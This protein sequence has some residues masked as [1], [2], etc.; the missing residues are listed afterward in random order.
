MSLDPDTSP[1]DLSPIAHKLETGAFDLFRMW[2]RQLPGNPEIVVR[3]EGMLVRDVREA[4]ERALRRLR[5]QP[6]QKTEVPGWS[7]GFIA[8]MVS[9]NLE[10][11][12]YHEYITRRSEAYQRFAALKAVE[13]YLKFDELTRIRV[14]RLYESFL[15]DDSN[16]EDIPLDAIKQDIALD[17][18]SPL[19]VVPTAEQGKVLALLNN[20]LLDNIISMS[21][22]RDTRIHLDVE[23]VFSWEEIGELVAGNAGNE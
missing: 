18:G 1:I 3:D 12:W 19:Q 21:K 13:A 9:G 16:L 7:R 14:D 22:Q 2:T 11:H 23:T 8:G 4:F 6:L 15:T 20:V 10:V 17:T 5:E